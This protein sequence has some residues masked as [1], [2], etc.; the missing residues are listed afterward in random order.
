M[1]DKKDL[2]ALKIIDLI[3]QFETDIIFRRGHIDSRIDHSRA[4]KEIIRRGKSELTGIVKHL[5]ELQFSQDGEVA[6]AWRNLLEELKSAHK[7]PG[8]VKSYMLLDSWIDWANG[9]ADVYIFRKP[10]G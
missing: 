7:F 4:R 9:Q 5:E 6:Y 10:P 2:T 1:N 8:D 3:G